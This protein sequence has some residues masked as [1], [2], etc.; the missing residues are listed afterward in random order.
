MWSVGVAFVPEPVLKKLEPMH[1]VTALSL[2][3]SGYII[4]TAIA[5]SALLRRQVKLLECMNCVSLD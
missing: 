5:H 1:H 3:P 2:L 4:V